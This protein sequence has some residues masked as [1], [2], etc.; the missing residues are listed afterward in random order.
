MKLPAFS[1]GDAVKAFKRSA[2]NSM[3]NTVATSFFDTPIH[4]TD[5]SPFPTIKNLPEELLER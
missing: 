3:S 4:R 1:G 2:K 5:A